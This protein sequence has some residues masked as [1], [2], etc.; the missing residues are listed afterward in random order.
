MRERE[1]GRKGKREGDEGEERG[2][3]RGREREGILRG[4]LRKRL[5][6]DLAQTRHISPFFSSTLSLSLDSSLS[7]LDGSKELMMLVADLA[8]VQD[9]EF[10]KYV[11]MYKDDEE[12]FFRDFAAA[13]KK[14]IELGVPAFH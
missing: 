9:P 13:W 1:R 11:R 14:L 5:S 2:R 7:L 12:L 6:R 10:V 4:R 3:G 8:L